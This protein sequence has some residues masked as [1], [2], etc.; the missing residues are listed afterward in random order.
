MRKKNII[1]FLLAFVMLFSVGANSFAVYAVGNGEKELA[2][3]NIVAN[4]EVVDEEKGIDAEKPE[5][6]QEEV[7]VKESEEADKKIEKVQENKETEKTEEKNAEEFRTKDS[8]EAID[9]GEEK[10]PEP[11]GVPAD[12]DLATINTIAKDNAGNY[13]G[14]KTYGN[15]YGDTDIFK[16]YYK[17][18]EAQ[19]NEVAKSCFMVFKRADGEPFKLQGVKIST[20]HIDDDNLK[21]GV[22]AGPI[23]TEIQFKHHM[24]YRL[25]FL[26]NNSP[27][28]VDGQEELTWSIT[29]KKDWVIERCP[30]FSDN[31][32]PDYAY[33]NYNVEIDGGGHN[34]YRKD[35]G[36]TGILQLGSGMSGQNVPVRTAKIKDLTI[37]GN[38]KY[39]GIELS[40]KGRLNLENVKIENCYADKNHYYYGGAIKLNDGAQL[41][42][43]ADTSI[44]NCKANIG[45]AIR[46]LD[47]CSL[48]INGSTFTNNQAD[49]GGAICALKENCKINIKDATFDGNKAVKTID[50]KYLQG[51]AIYT[52]SP[53]NISDTTFMN[54]NS[55]KNGGAIIS[56]ADTTISRCNF[57]ENSST[58]G[59][60]GAVYQGEGKLTIEKNTF[61]KDIAK[62][63]GGAIYAVTNA[64]ATITNSIFSENK[65]KWGGA[66]ANYSKSIIN[67]VTFNKN[68]ATSTGGAIYTGEGI[69]VEESSLVEN[70]ANKGGAIYISKGESEIKNTSF[71]KNES[72]NGG[73]A[74]FIN[75]DNKGTTS[76]SKTSFTENI[77][78]AFGGGIYLGLN[79]KLDVNESEFT[80]NQAAYGAGI[81]SAADGNI[82][83]DLSNIKVEGTSFTEN[84]ALDGA[85]IFTA[86]PAEVSTS[87]FKKNMAHVH[88]QDDQKNPHFSGVGGAIRVMDN[89]TTIKAS[90]FEDNFAGG[91]GGAIGINGLIRDDDLKITGIK[92]NIKVDISDGTKFIGNICNVGQGGAI[93]TIPYLYDI[94]N[95]E[96]AVDKATLKVNAY[97][98]LSTSADTIFKD[99]V[100]LTGF[101]DP[102]TNYKDYTDLK[103]KTNSF[104]DM[105]SDKDL[106][107]SLLNNYDVNYM[108]KKLSA[109]FD[110]NGGEFKDGEKPKDIRVIKGEKDKEIKLLAAPKRDGYKFTGWKLSMN[111]PKDKLKEIPEET[112]KL[113]KEGK[114]YKAGEKFTLDADYIFVAQ[115]EKD[116]TPASPSKPE[117]KPETKPEPEPEI[118]FKKHEYVETFPVIT[119][120][121]EKDNIYSH[122]R[123]LFGYP[124]DTIKPE[125]NMTRAEA[126]AVVTR[127]EGYSFKDESERIFKD[128]KKGAWYNKYINAAFEKGILVEKEGQAF[129]PDEAITR[130]EFAKLISFID[131]DNSKIA[132]FPDV[133]GHVY[134]DA[135]N[136][137]YG[138]DRIKGYPDGSFRPDAKITRA[139][140]VTILNNFYDRKAD[141]KSLENVENIKMLKHFKDLKEDY[142]AYYEITE[143]ANSH[144]FTRRSKGL[145]ENWVHL[146]EDLEK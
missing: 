82:D 9:L 124:D 58:E 43:D 115:W 45:G 8:E 73:G 84:E 56:Y 4:A 1:G 28:K 66:I 33:V 21:D 125:G 37:E 116:D 49:L 105:L 79:G 65:A 63:S 137:A 70:K 135:I 78:N 139:E 83:T 103:F 128:L 24:A 144:K 121:A 54:N 61:T 27:L 13:Y 12:F 87:T 52:N 74:I 93:Y 3:E 90:S 5:D 100:A 50:G 123:Y 35:D 32:S 138:N 44:S 140:I 77:S 112:L 22:T 81:S 91:S 51:G 114:I 132:P 40:Q 96:T 98:N 55:D 117:P 59:N 16:T 62:K 113:L 18:T 7:V 2:L 133:K 10:V 120:L 129:R 42:M 145:L 102:P 143:A 34:I 67:N 25:G 75:H 88:P 71:T 89:K 38:N 23:F 109:I 72:K 134:E 95:Q 6:S 97:K 11:V 101:V 36:V 47:N 130:A 41:T 48:T 111:I 126:V 20:S 76:I 104:T 94:E 57:T 142:W 68:E 131:A 60:G 141:D 85:G 118:K 26:L 19:Y 108:N 99:N 30:D 110:P 119:K 31:S 80:K 53:L 136:K 127:L 122:I 46:L 106:A 29:L 64:P 15:S 14:V 39:Y 107:K 69:T 17:I 86:F 92:P 146:I